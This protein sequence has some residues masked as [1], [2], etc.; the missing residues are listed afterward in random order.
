MA[1]HEKVWMVSHCKK[2]SL[3]TLNLLT[4][5]MVCAHNENVCCDTSLAG[6]QHCSCKSS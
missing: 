3:T 4:G 1:C 2:V 6:F 5:K